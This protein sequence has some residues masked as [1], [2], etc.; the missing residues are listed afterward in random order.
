MSNATASQ[1]CSAIGKP[2]SCSASPVSDVL[3][4]VLSSFVIFCPAFCSVRFVS[5]C[6]ALAHQDVLFASQDAV[7]ALSV[8]MSVLFLLRL[9]TV[10]KYK[11]KRAK[12]KRSR[13][14]HVTAATNTNR[15]LTAYP[16][17]DDQTHVLLWGLLCTYARLDFFSCCTNFFCSCSVF[18][19]LSAFSSVTIRVRCAFS[20]RLHHNYCAHSK[21]SQAH[22]KLFNLRA[23][24]FA[25]SQNFTNQA[26]K[27]LC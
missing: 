16:W 21:S 24:S 15:C 20:H 27:W 7:A 4:S 25:F 22:Y 11:L 19:E 6:T 5:F 3:C 10:V 18:A 23:C 9:S 2:T 14:T 12:E 17:R 13:N 26:K 1:Y 8:F